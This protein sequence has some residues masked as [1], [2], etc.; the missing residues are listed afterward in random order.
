MSKG[1]HESNSNCTVPEFLLSSKREVQ[2]SFIAALVSPSMPLP[3]KSIEINDK[4]MLI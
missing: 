2:S 3:R 1:L 4:G